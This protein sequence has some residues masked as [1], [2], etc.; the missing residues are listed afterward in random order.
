M[1]PSFL[2]GGSGWNWCVFVSALA[3]SFPPSE[4]SSQG[5]LGRGDYL[6]SV[7]PVLSILRRLGVRSTGLLVR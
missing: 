5:M 2:K 7:N 6:K 3:S 4:I 1:F